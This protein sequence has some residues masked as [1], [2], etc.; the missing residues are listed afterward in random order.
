MIETISEKTRARSIPRMPG[1]VWVVLGLLLSMAILNYFDRQTLSILK[2][3][4]KIE[5]GFDDSGYSLLTF[6]FMLT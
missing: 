1:K 3:T 4:L 2:S 6:A 5:L